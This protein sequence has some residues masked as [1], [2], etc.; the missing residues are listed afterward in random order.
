MASRIMHYLIATEVA[1]RVPIENE[2]RFIFGNLLPDCVNG[3][4]GRTGVKGFSHFSEIDENTDTKGVNWNVFCEKYQVHMTD[5]IYLGYMCHLL[6]DTIWYHDVNHPLVRY[7]DE[8]KWKCHVEMM[9]RDYHR[10]NE[11]LRND[12]ELVAPKIIWLENEIEEVEP[13]FWKI[14][15][16]EFA[17]DFLESQGAVWQDMELLTYDILFSYIEKAVKQ[18]GKEILAKKQGRKGLDPKKYFVPKERGK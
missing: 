8:A 9:Y 4:G 7:M 13:E 15:M 1:K 11:I 12:F 18:A 14:Y 6:A 10:L 17:E 16:G 3:P 2:E 5:D